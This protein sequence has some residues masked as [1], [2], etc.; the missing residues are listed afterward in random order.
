VIICIRQMHKQ[1]PMSLKAPQVM[2]NWNYH[3]ILWAKVC[4]VK[5]CWYKSMLLEKK[6]RR[7][8]GVDLEKIGK[9]KQNSQESERQGEI[10]LPKEC[11][12]GFVWTPC[13]C[14][15]LGQADRLLL[16]FRGHGL[17]D[18]LKFKDG[19]RQRFLV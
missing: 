12:K 6:I 8:F 18:Y 15:S 11:L 10:N 13:D 16:Q 14:K 9:W 3:R 2:I 7:G 17:K 5:Q 4:K 1:A 19:A